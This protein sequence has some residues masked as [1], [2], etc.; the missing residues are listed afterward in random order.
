MIHY[1]S[2]YKYY[3]VSQ[4]NNHKEENNEK[5]WKRSQIL[6]DG[7][8]RSQYVNGGDD[9]KVKCVEEVDVIPEGDWRR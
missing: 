8:N 9:V 3:S 2:F 1:K 6:L 5:K 7:D 4:H